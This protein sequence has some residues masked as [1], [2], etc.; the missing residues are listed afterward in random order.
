VILYVGLNAVYFYGAS[1]EE[2][3]GQVEVGLIASRNL[4][5]D[6]GATLVT[7]VLCVSILASASAMTIA[8]ARVYYA[9]GRDTTVL[10]F[11]GRAGTGSGAPTA[12]LVLQGGVTS[13]IILSGRIDQIQQYAGFTITLFGSLAV[14]CVIV[15]RF[16]RPDMER[17]FKTWGY[18]VTP[19][20]SRGHHH[21]V[22]HARAAGRI[23]AQFRHRGGR[24]PVVLR[25]RRQKTRDNANRLLTRS[26]FHRNRRRVPLRAQAVRRKVSPATTRSTIS[27]DSGGSHRFPAIGAESPTP[28]LPVCVKPTAPR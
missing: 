18:P 14:L 4:F 11:L 28:A 10:G 7:V 2:L 8:G 6:T 3:E 20:R 22:G 13:I 25:V 5:G 1:L 23:V 24:R 17:P 12:A 9:F 19:L 26:T 21:D 16:R 15:L 27:E